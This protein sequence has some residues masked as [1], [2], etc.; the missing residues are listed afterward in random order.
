MP[1]GTPPMASAF[2]TASRALATDVLV[3]LE[4]YSRLPLPDRVRPETLDLGA[5]GRA[6]RVAPIAGALIGGAGAVGLILAGPVLGLPPWI[7]AVLALSVVILC[8]GA[9]HEDGLADVADGF[10]GGSTRERK[11][12]IMRDSRI[13]TFGA[14]ALVL[15]LLLRAG[16]LWALV[17]RHGAAGGA[18]VLIAVG[19]ASRGFGLLPLAMLPPA[20]TDGLARAVGS[21]PRS[22]VLSAFGLATLLGTGVPGLAGIGIWRGVSAC[23]AAAAAS[24]GLTSL[25]RQQIGGQ[26]GDV[27]GAAQQLSE[28][29]F[30]LALLVLPSLG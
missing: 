14:L 21:L 6:T 28:V 5:F 15:S 20:R 12:E 23:A 11:L 16:A 29:A 7:A 19:A 17:E 30:L 13:G 2:L 27:S 10:G 3:C 9:L 1:N 25:A 18:A 4:F 26:T 24:W 8:G 22:A